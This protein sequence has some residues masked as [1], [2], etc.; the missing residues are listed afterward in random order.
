MIRV[1]AITVSLLKLK[2]LQCTMS[3][4]GS[5]NRSCNCDLDLKS[6][7]GSSDRKTHLRRNSDHDPLS[8]TLNSK[9]FS[10]H[11]P[12]RIEDR[13]HHHVAHSVYLTLVPASFLGLSARCFLAVLGGGDS[14]L[15][16]YRIVSV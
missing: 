4:T 16:R 12:C 8:S 11:P 9:P 5:G 3:S 10:L 15:A 6:N 1:A 14:L 13:Q 7:H 2:C